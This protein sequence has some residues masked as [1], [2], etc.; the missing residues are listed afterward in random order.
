[1]Y[2][3]THH[4]TP[5]PP[6]PRTNERTKTTRH[7]RESEAHAARVCFRFVSRRW[8]F[9]KNARGVGDWSFHRLPC[10]SRSLTCVV[11]TVVFT[12]FRARKPSRTSRTRFRRLHPLLFSF[13]TFSARGRGRTEEERGED[14]ENASRRTH[15]NETKQNA[16]GFVRRTNERANETGEKRTNER[17]RTKKKRKRANVRE[18]GEGYIHILKTNKVGRTRCV[19]APFLFSV[20]FFV[21]CIS[22][23]ESRLVDLHR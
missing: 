19:I 21:F 5:T 10:P 17:T 8:A 1:M 6:P 15:R 9:I 3:R 4:I 12:A 2:N 20:S 16:R 14:V 23:N 11:V 18:E 13:F 7:S 22:R